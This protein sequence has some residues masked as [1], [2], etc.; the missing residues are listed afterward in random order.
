VRPHGRQEPAEPMTDPATASEASHEKSTR[1]HG[2]QKRQR[3][4]SINV[5]LT[6]EERTAAEAKAARAGLSLSGYAR[7]CLLGDSGPRAVRRP[8]LE[9]QLFGKAIAE[10]NKIGSNINQVAHAANTGRILDT[11]MLSRMTAELSEAVNVL[12]E[13]AG[14]R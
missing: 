3:I 6:V 1:H 5:A 8:P 4:K 14:K 10:L 12:L 7:A 2:S 11:V 9:I 13:A